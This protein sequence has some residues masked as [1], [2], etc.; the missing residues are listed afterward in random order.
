M[1]RLIIASFAAILWT[2]VCGSV[3]SAQT[4][5]DPAVPPKLTGFVPSSQGVL[6]CERYLNKRVLLYP[7]A[8]DIKCSVANAVAIGKGKPFS[9]E[10]CENTA[11]KSCK[12][13]YDRAL[14][15]LDDR[16]CPACLDDP[17]QAALFPNFRD[18]VKSVN[19]M[20]YCEAAGCTPLDDASGCV[21]NT[22]DTAR[23]Q[24]KAALN[25]AKL[26]KCLKL[27][28]HQR[29]A[30]DLFWNRLD[31][32]GNNFVCEDQDPFSSCKARFIKDMG[33]L[34]GCPS[35]LL[36][37]VTHTAETLFN[38]VQEAVDSRNGS[39]YCGG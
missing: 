39:I 19:G 5:L 4:P 7:L 30:E 38:A 2:T 35:C 29:T 22:R 9:L 31:P 25:V 32:P 1:R 20:I 23:C 36:D 37:G 10:E 34:V 12:A 27:R 28:C 13:Q 21:S 6:G 3:V 15:K 18:V 33:K 14:A 11:F 24:N 16:E 26:F 17:A 8:C